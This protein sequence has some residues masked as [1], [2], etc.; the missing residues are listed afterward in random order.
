[1]ANVKGEADRVRHLTVFQPAVRMVLVEAWA[2]ARN[3]GTIDTGHRLLPVIG[4]Q[5]MAYGNFPNG[6]G[7]GDPFYEAVVV[8]EDEGLMTEREL[9]HGCPSSVLRWAVSWWPPTEDTE[10]LEKLIDE[11]IADA[12]EGAA[13]RRDQGEAADRPRSSSGVNG[14]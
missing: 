1:M 9:L 10:R 7:D 13:W 4:V 11:A 2:Y 3:D 14:V 5:G 6:G 8:T 12:R